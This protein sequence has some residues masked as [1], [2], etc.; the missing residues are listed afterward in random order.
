MK[1]QLE[2]LIH[3]E[4]ITHSRC[5]CLLIRVN[6]VK[7]KNKEQQQKKNPN[8]QLQGDHVKARKGRK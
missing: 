7:N 2:I 6:F 3:L 4:K 8:G 1:I 5:Y